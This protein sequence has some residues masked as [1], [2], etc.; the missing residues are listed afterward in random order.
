MVEAEEPS[1]AAADRL[2]LAAAQG[3]RLSPGELQLVLA[4]VAQAGFDPHARERARGELAGIVWRGQMLQGSSWLPPA[5]R[6]SLKHVLVRHE[7]PDSTTLEDYLASI[8]A[9]ILDPM[10]GVATRN[11]QQRGWHLTIARHSGSWR[12]PRGSSWILVDYRVLTGHWQTAFQF[13]E[14]PALKLHEG[15]TDVRWQRRPREWR[16]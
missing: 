5:K 13:P 7:W 12:G 15:A 8:R 10:S 6:H 2:L 3:R 9:V 16:R 11:Y 14:D 1:P 4:H